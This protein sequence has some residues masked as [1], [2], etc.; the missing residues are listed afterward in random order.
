MQVGRLKRDLESLNEQ[1]ER[2]REEAK[3][4]EQ[5]RMQLEAEIKVGAAGARAGAHG[6]CLGL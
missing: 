2:A 4:A 6:C 1:R 5:A 3:R